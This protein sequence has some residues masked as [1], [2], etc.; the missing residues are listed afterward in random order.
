MRRVLTDGSFLVRVLVAGGLALRVWHYLANHTIWYD[1]AVLLVNVMEKDFAGL[2]GPMHHAVAAP[3]L[4]VWLLKLIHLAAGDVPYVWRLVPFAFSVLG[5]LLTVPL[6]RRVLPPPAAV[7]AVGLVAVSDN[8]IWLGCC[9][10]PYAG[11]DAVSTALLLFLAATGNWPAAKRLLVLAAVSPLLL[12][13]SYT[14]VFVIPAMLFV[15]APA[16]WRSGARGRLAWLLASATTAGTLAVLYFGPMTAQRVDSLVAEWQPHFLPHSDP[17]AAVGWVVQAVFGVFQQASNPSGVVLAALA[18]LGVWGLWRAGRREVATACVGMFGLAI[19]AAAVKAYPFGQH[20]LSQF[21]APA[22]VV[23]GA[24]GVEEIIRRWKWVGVTLA[25]LLVAVAD[26]LS[27]AH[28]VS[29]WHR[30]DAKGVQRYVQAHR[31]PGDVVLSNEGNYLYFFVGELKPIEAGGAEVPV[32][33]RAWV[34]M[35]FYNRQGRREYIDWRLRP[36][37]F[38]LVEDVEFFDAGVYLYV[39]K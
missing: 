9:V 5:L 16:A 21:L 1:E 31:R 33:G 37:G 14:T 2:L 27:L 34:V 36:L 4:F 38:E 26:G 24:A 13:F 35:D 12:C 17:V 10:K 29:P 11:D 28:L 22:A 8:H 7:L 25:V 18:P 39:R 30:P 19:L 3:P 23:L 15:L 20:R 32:G 6:A